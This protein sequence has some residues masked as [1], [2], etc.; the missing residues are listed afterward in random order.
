MHGS[1]ADHTSKPLVLSFFGFQFSLRKLGKG[2]Q[3]ARG[4]NPD[5]HGLPPRLTFTIMGLQLALQKVSARLQSRD[6]WHTPLGVFLGLL[7]TCFLTR[8]EDRWLLSAE[9]LQTAFV[10]LLLFTFG[11]LVRSVWDS[12]NAG[13][14]K[15]ILAEVCGFSQA[16][17]RDVSVFFIRALDSAGNVKLLTYFDQGWDSWFCKYHTAG[18]AE[19]DPVAS[20]AR[21]AA[22]AFGVPSNTIHVRPMEGVEHTEEKASK[23]SGDPRYY[24][25]QFFFMSFEASVSERFAAPDFL[26]QDCRYS[27]KT[28]EELLAH[29]GTRETNVRFNGFLRDHFTTFLDPTL[30][31]SV[32]MTL[33][34]AA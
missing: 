3:R 13:A 23:V 5:A 34:D 8:F 31:M 14:S 1:A 18:A 26:L 33:Q 10:M 25:Y 32:Q 22:N 27:W 6:R 12:R 4:A 28:I 30:Q 21:V 16:S 2:H 15:D 24:R 20:I 19:P 7:P 29:P 11:W 9:Q 17:F